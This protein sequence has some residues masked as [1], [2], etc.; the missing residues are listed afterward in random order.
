[1]VRALTDER[2]QGR[3]LC[4]PLA[5]GIA[6]GFE[7]RCGI[8]IAKSTQLRERLG[9]ALHADWRGRAQFGGEDGDA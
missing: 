2:V 5:S 1:M 7:V 9:Q 3:S 8:A 4:Q 6:R